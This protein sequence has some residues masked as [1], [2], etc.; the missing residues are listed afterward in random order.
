MIVV[1]SWILSATNV[2][3]K[4]SRVFRYVV[5]LCV[6]IFLFNC[7][8]FRFVFVSSFINCQTFVSFFASTRYQRKHLWKNERLYNFFWLFEIANE[9]TEKILTKLTK[10]RYELIKRNR[11]LWEISRSRFTFLSNEKFLK[12][13]I[14]IWI[15]RK[16]NYFFVLWWS[17]L[18]RY[19]DI[20]YWLI[21]QLYSIRLFFVFDA[22][23]LELWKYCW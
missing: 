20:F 22:F 21:N 4:R 18:R 14:W 23:S 8:R 2:L 19:N 17:I 16:N 1:V 7:R 6:Y 13:M 3:N 5:N 15:L 10:K 12:C 9:M 11:F